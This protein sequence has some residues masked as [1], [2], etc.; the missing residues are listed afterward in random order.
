MSINNNS[1]SDKQKQTKETFG[2]KWNAIETYQ[3]DAVKNK[4]RNWLQERYTPPKNSIL[5]DFLNESKRVILDAGCGAGFSA[6]LLFGE[7]LNDHKYIGVDISDAISHAKK[8]IEKICGDSEFIKADIS[9]I[10]IPENSLD[11]IFSEGVLHHTD[12]PEKT[13]NHLVTKLKING[14]FLFYVYKK[15]A[16]IREFTDD[17]IRNKLKHYSNEEAWEKLIPLTKLGKVIGDLNIDI[18]IDEDIELLE[19]PKGKHNIQRLFYWYICKMYFRDEYSIQEMNHINFD[20]F[21]PLNC[22]RYT[23]E[24]IEHWCKNNNMFIEHSNV[25]DS[26]ITIIARKVR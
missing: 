10:S 12:N 20:W 2:F 23:F 6:E 1:I 8:R 16:P 15:K 22:F 11:L 3:S 21:R 9:K 17:F 13:F 7:K 4:T 24:E 26:G 5:T 18:E 19:I 25:Q 14:L